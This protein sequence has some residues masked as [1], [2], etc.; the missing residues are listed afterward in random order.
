MGIRQEFGRHFLIYVLLAAATVAVY[1]QVIDFDFVNFDDGVYVVDNPYV[2]A[3]LTRETVRWALTATYQ[4]T[5]QPLTWMSYMLDA[6]VAGVDP[7]MFHATNVAL[8][9]ANTFLVFWVLRAFLGFKWRAAFV[10]MLFAVHP[11]HVESV[12]WVAERKDVLSTLFWLLA[13]AAYLRY[14]RDREPRKHLTVVVLFALGLMA[15]PMVVT[16]PLVLLLLDY[17]PLGRFAREIE[18]RGSLY[19]AGR[20][21]VAEK[22]PLFVLSAASA[23]VTS[24][25]MYLA[26]RA[27]G[28]IPV[29]ELSLPFGVRLA[30]ALV[31][32]AAYI[33]RAFWPAKLA[34]FYPHPGYS[35]PSWQVVGA[36]VLLAGVTA[37]VFRQAR[38]RPYLLVGWLWYIVT[39][40]PAIGIMQPGMHGM[41]DRFTY[42]PF[43]G[44]FIMIAWGV[45]DLLAGLRRGRTL[46]L[47][48]S[49]AAAMLALV[50]VSYI[51]VGYWRDTVT[52]F[53][54]ALQ[55][56]PPNSVSHHALGCA[57]HAR[58]DLEGALKHYVA[59]LRFD[60][61]NPKILNDAGTALYEM[62]DIDGAMPYYVRAL[63]IKP[64]FPMALNNMGSVLMSK[65]E[66]DAAIARFKA[67]LRLDPGMRSARANLE[68]ART[69]KEVYQ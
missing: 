35:L 1:W 12:A 33:V 19:R 69:L 60:P 32:Y 24:Y 59:A 40:L 50:T 18:K 48:S 49:S 37:F 28:A 30:N 56:T 13:M 9:L 58:G 41:A 11:M 38:A 7:M 21:L 2:H 5:W 34:V 68:Q 10:A 6:T 36:T 31:S 39:L 66:L 53:E 16:L 55:V 61:R 14:T 47:A 57:L 63:S 46:V 23:L 17:W 64:N 42:I 54:R 22:M 25:T 3:G 44:V 45:P 43:I 65:G 20:E 8:H 51:Q 26:P 29:A 52:L 27:S 15:K 62:G 4:C 67:A